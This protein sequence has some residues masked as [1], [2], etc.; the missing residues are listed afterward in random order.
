MASR[1]KSARSKGNSYERKIVRELRE[2][3]LFPDAVTSR[4]ES[5]RTDDKGIDIMYTDPF[6]FQL[7]AVERLGNIHKILNGMPNDNNYNVVIHKR[8]NQGEVVSMS[9]DDFYEILGMLI[10]NQIL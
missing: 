4:S 9:K 1:G 3:L 8:N 6:N 2:Y 10:R 7:K 5:K